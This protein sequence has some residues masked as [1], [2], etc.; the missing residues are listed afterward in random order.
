VRLLIDTDTAADDAVALLMAVTAPGVE[1]AA[2]TTVAGNVSV[3]QATS[4]ALKVLHV[5]GRTDVPVHAGAAGPL[6]RELVH[7]TDVHGPDGMG[8]HWFPAVG[9]QAGADALE[10]TLDVLRG[11][12]G[13]VTWVAL[14]PLTNLALAVEADPEACRRVRQI[15]VMGGAPD[16][17]GNV[18]PA[19]EFN[20][21][22]DPEAARTVFAAGLPVRLVGYDIGR[23]DALVGPAELDRLRASDSTLA[24]FTVDITRGLWDFCLAR[25]QAGMDLCD[26]VAM[27]AA[28]HPQSATWEAHA[29]DVHVDDEVSRGA[30]VCPAGRAANVE[31]C[32]RFDPDR[33][34]ALLFERLEVP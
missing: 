33:F 17:V 16:G 24:A 25:G 1:V 6:L 26:P 29:V 12:P 9:K 18:T 31:L 13:E 20:L 34:R 22:V 4:N 32:T 23:R 15:V 7:A 14:G 27:A 28:L 3:E 21:W 8:G 19:A 30:L 5:C 2:I 10:A 11:N